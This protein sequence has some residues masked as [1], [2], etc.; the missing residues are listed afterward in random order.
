MLH[1]KSQKQLEWS[2]STVMHVDE[3]ARCAGRELPSEQ[4]RQGP[5]GWGSASQRA[6]QGAAGGQMGLGRV[7]RMW[8]G[9]GTVSLGLQSRLWVC[10]GCGA[11]AG[12]WGQP[13]ALIED[14]INPGCGSGCVLT[15]TVTSRDR[16]GDV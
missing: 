9:P 12:A 15:V 16:M 6:E 8:L 1:Q 10:A 13:P 3:A 7:R 11:A 4:H 2:G 5:E 14:P